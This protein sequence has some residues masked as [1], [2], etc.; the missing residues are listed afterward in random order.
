LA[1]IGVSVDQF[2]LSYFYSAIACTDREHGIPAHF[3]PVM[4]TSTSPVKAGYRFGPFAL[5]LRSGDLSRNGRP[6]R[7]QEKPRS[8]LMALA[9]R[10]SEL[11]TRKEL[12]ERLWPNDT[13]VDFEDG[14]NAAMSKLREAL[15]DNTQSPKYIETVRGRGYRFMA[16]V[17]V[18][19]E[20]EVVAPAPLL[21]A[22]PD[23]RPDPAPLLAV[24][25]GVSRKNK[26]AKVGAGILLACL[27]AGSAV[28]FVVRWRA[29]ARPISIAVLPFANMTGDSSRDYVGNGITEELIVRLDRLSPGHLRVIA[30]ASARTYANTSK[31]PQQIGRELSVQ[32]LVEGSLQQQGADVRVSVQLVRVDDQSRVWANV[33][34]GDL[35]DQFAFEDSVADSVGHALSLHVPSL[36]RAEYRPGKYEA[37]DAYLKGLYFSSKR[38]K[39]GFE[40]AI[41]SFSNAVSID[42]KYAA[43]YAQLADMYNLMGQYGWM[44]PDNA[45]SLGWAAAKQALSLDSSLA[46]AHAALGFSYWYYQWD[47][48]AAEAEFRNAI[49]LEPDNVDAH[50]WYEQLLMTAGRFPEAEQQM[51]AAL[52]VD[53]RSGILRTNLGWLYEFEGRLPQAAQQVQGVLT[54]NPNFFPAHYKLWYIYSV[55][56]DLAH[57]SGEFQWVVQSAGGP[58]QHENA[59]SSIGPQEYRA[60]LEDLVRAHIGK[61]TGSLVDG[62]RC[63]AFAGDS[64][65]ALNLLERAYQDH[66]GWM[67]YVQADPAFA[68]LHADPRFQ[69]LIAQVRKKS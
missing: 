8:L 58:V 57:S 40:Q 29:H 52:D 2:V 36:I 27:A 42:P 21:P 69:R 6:I 23:S 10:R 37:H 7:L 34:E 25:I 48:S 60:A 28:L 20:P 63:L 61:D 12:H 68:G 51:Q 3:Y 54:E 26:L 4:A 16:K 41:E 55:M 5:D 67:V 39:P 47:F 53:P 24:S 50:H 64:N 44:N 30:P 56:G 19:G 65:G 1:K 62:A 13:F 31:P 35:S 15:D 33:Y 32:Y 17:E 38:T 66:E 49:A 18:V 9:E 22:R 45:R 14:L 43:A 46:E 11:V 59:P